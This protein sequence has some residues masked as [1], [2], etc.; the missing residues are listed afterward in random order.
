MQRQEQLRAERRASEQRDRMALFES[1]LSV[2]GIPLE[3]ATYLNE[4]K[5]RAIFRAR[6]RELHPDA[7]DASAIG[8]AEGVGD[9]QVEGVVVPT[10]YELNAA[11]EAVKGVL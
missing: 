9:V 5:L 2:L 8:E 4:R 6:S 10:I 11:Y 7:R 3:E 1:E